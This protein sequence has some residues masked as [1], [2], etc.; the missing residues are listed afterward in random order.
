MELPS[1]ISD[2]DPG[3]LV[4]RSPR[5]ARARHRMLACT[6]VAAFVLGF[7]VAIGLGT[8]V[9][10]LVTIVAVACALT[11]AVVLMRGRRPSLAPLRPAADRAIRESRRVVARVEAA[12]KERSAADD[13]VTRQRE[14]LRMNVLGAQ[15]RRAG[16]GAAAAEQH[17]AALKIF[18]ELGDRRS[19]ALT[20]NNLALALRDAGDVDSSVAALELAIAILRELGDDE[21]EGR[22]IAN[23]GFVHQ[24]VGRSE[25]AAELLATALA[26]LPPQSPDYARVEAQLLRAS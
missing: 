18:E 13:S 6:G 19:T 8:L 12:W 21:H 1:F 20:L 16:D 26:K 3:V 23:L 7:L 2:F 11:T 24:R 14:A 4:E 15:L 25:E 10:A 22:V 5:G 17:R 9:L